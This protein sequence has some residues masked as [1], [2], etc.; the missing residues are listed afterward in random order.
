M[1][2]S[3]GLLIWDRRKSGILGMERD[4]RLLESVEEEKRKRIGKGSSWIKLRLLGYFK[5]V[6]P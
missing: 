2:E 6:V 4:L 1:V 5:L 3:D